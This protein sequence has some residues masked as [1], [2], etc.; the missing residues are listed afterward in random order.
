MLDLE[1]LWPPAPT[2]SLEQNFQPLHT[3]VDNFQP[4]YKLAANKHINCGRPLKD[5]KVYYLL[6]FKNT[7]SISVHSK[8]AY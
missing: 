8:P 2:Q 6:P 1:C 3:G 7:Q 5:S 4:E